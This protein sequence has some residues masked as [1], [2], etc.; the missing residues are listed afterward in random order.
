MKEGTKALWSLGDYSPDREVHAAPASQALLDACAVSAGQEVL[1]VAA[2]TGNFA[3]L[4]AAEGASVVASDLTPHLIERG[5]QRTGRGGRRHRVGRGRRRGAAVR[6]RALRL[7][8]LGVRR[9]VRAAA[10]ARPPRR[11]SASRGP[12]NT[13]GM[14]NWTPEGF[15]GRVFAMMN[16]YAPRPEGVPAPIEWGTED[17]V[18]ERFDGLAGTLELDRRTCR[19][20]ST[21]STRCI[22]FFENAGPQVAAKQALGPGDLRRDAPAVQGDRR[23]VQPGR[24]RQRAHRE[25]VPARRRPEARAD[26]QA[27]HRVRR[28]ALRGLGAAGRAADRAGRD[29]GGARDGSRR[30][31]RAHRR[32]PHRRRRPRARAGREPRRRAAPA[33]RLERQP[34]RRRR[35][36]ASEPAPDGF[37]ARRDAMARAY[38][39][40]VYTRESRCRRSSA[41]ARCTGRIRSTATALDAC[42]ALLPGKH[43]FTAFTPTQTEHVL[44]RARTSRCAEWVDAGEHV[45]EFRI[46]AP[47]FMRNQV[48]IL[49]GTMLEVGQGRAQRR[50]TSQRAASRAGRAA[51]RGRPP[52]RTVST[53]YRCEVRRDEGPAHK[54]RRH[55][56]HGAQPHAPRAARAA[57]HRAGRDRAG[58]EPQ[59]HR[60]QHHHPP[61]ALGRGD[62]LRR[63]HDR[64]RHR[65][66]AGGL[67]PLRGARP[68]RVPARADHLGHQPRRE[69]GRRHHL[70]GHRRGR[71]RGRRAR[72]PGDRRVAAV[73]QGRD[74]L[75]ARRPVRLRAGRG[76]RRARRRRARRRARSRR[77]R[78]STSTARTATPRARR[79]ASSASGSTATSCT[80]P[81]RRATAASTGSTATTRA[82]TTRTAPTS[83]RSPT[84]TSPSPRSTST[85]RTIPAS[86]SSGTSTSTG[87]C[88]RPP[89]RFERARPTAPPS[90]GASS[91]TTTTATTSSTTRRSAT[92]STTRC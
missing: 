49:V 87:C 5:K 43:D 81:R 86:R 32:R 16:E 4:A 2:G 44:L 37:D 74:G 58:L 84:A 67:R 10:A 68:G 71:A 65:R 36:L 1:D 18:R 75:P 9:D 3:L 82:T 17:A 7:H 51:R 66:H 60:A 19:S 38:R 41:G 55:P 77:A 91:S 52:R 54:R 40:R 6:R 63:R 30:A 92:T 48:R 8:G 62:R 61:P 31:G 47:S 25:R 72:H 53:L 22:A 78:C 50:A 73:A 45:L 21:R 76:V 11:C 83:P 89:K 80:S 26:G 15:N 34:A 69:P 35:V 57:R 33:R 28:L 14:A 88:S 46:E 42:A 12:G 79:S 13:V 24:R 20:S 90:C 23:R 85:S 39:Y 56:G 29:G 27:P 64:L 59:R 70:L